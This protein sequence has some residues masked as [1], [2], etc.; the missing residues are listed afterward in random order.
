MKNPG[1]WR[2]EGS[3]ESGESSKAKGLREAELV[4]TLR[5]A[6]VIEPEPSKQAGE[7]YKP[8]S[9]GFEVRQTHMA[10]ADSPYPSGMT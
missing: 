6:Q 1:T 4:S 8:E 3:A 2:A 7:W 10:I 5:K 9:A